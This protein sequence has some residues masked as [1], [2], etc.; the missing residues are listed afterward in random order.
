MSVKAILDEKGRQVVTVDPQTKVRQAIGLL[1]ENRIG[2]VVIVKPGDKIAGILTE[3]DVVAA[4]ARF[5]A[6]CLDKTV[7][8]VMW[9]KVYSCTEDMT[10]NDIMEI[11]NNMRA[12]HL[13]VEK[14]GRLV[15]IVSIGDAVRHHIR[16]I[17]R[18]AEQIKAYIAG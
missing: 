14:S 1:H 8:A 18:E 16:A 5:G 12:R 3:R 11:M 4:M 7:S 6:D 10:I 15:G 2:A 9:S 17:E 13:P